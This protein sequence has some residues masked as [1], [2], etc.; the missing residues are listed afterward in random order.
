MKKN[1]QLAQQL[2]SA[3]LF[4][5]VIVMLGW[6]SVRYKTQLD[7]TAGKR[8]TLT[9]ASVKLLDS[10]KDP[11]TLHA[12]VPSGSD[13]RRGLEQDLARY[14]RVKKDI[15]LDFIDPTTHPQDVQKYNIQQVGEVVL[16]YQGRRETLHA[17]TEQAISTA[18]QR[19]SYGGEQ[20]VVFLEGHGERSANDSQ[21]Q[22]AA[23]KFAQALRDKG[24][25][26]NS[27][28]LVKQPKVP[29]N[30]S[31]LVIASPTAQP[32]AGEVELIKK[33]LDDG[34]DLLWLADPE[35]PAGMEP[36]AKA[37]GI[38][39]QDGYV[40]DPVAQQLG[41]P[42]GFYVPGDYPPNPVTQGME[43]VTLF[44]LARSLT[45]DKNAG[46]QAQEM[47]K[48]VD[49]S[50]L[51]TGDISKGEV[52][53]DGKDIKGPLTVGL[54]LTRQHKGADGKEHAQRVALI[55]DVDFLSNAFI[56]QQGNQQLAINL[57]QWLASRDA[58]LNIDIPKAPDVSLYLPGWGLKLIVLGLCIVLPL[59]LLGYGVGRWIVR[60]RK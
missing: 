25:K 59:S 39:W 31:V 53:F 8:N 21:A 33:Y 49:E 51:E 2:L 1:S 57:V 11:I 46:W 24:L 43:H 3:L 16:E 45:Y 36:L 22:E 15:T 28:S 13:D 50:W 23:G 27:L 54:T 4:F 44:P 52:K 20:W 26:V 42:A 14:T 40:I 34:G 10:M 37:L 17:T 60:R 58:Q 47:L 38:S 41:L 9:E 5:A 7:W 32:I 35:S 55:G 29:D 56:A 48:S 12:F 18:L 6:L 30:A 19:L